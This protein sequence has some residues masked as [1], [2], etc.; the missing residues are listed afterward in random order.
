MIRN[1]SVRT[2]LLT[3]ALLGA[4]CAAWAATGDSFEIKV[5]PVARVT[6]AITIDGDLAESA[7]D[8]APLVDEFTVYGKSDL[9]DPQTH[10]RVI[11][12]DSE[13]LLGIR[14]DEPNMQR[15]TPVGHPRDSMGVF[16][17]ETVEIFV[18]PDHDQATYYQIAVN[19]AESIYDSVKTDPTWSA[20]V[21][22]GVELYD[23]HWTMEVAIPWADLGVAPERGALVGL[24]V[25]RDRYLGAEKSW[26]NWA[27]TSGGW[28]DPERFG[29]IVLSPSASRIGEL[30]E[31]LHR[32]GRSGPV[33]IYG[34]D[35]FVQAANRALAMTAIDQ[36]RE[37]LARLDETRKGEADAAA[38]KEL[39]RRIEDYR[40]EL[41]DFEATATDD[42]VVPREQWREMNHRIAQ[43]R[44]ELH[45]VIWQARVSALLSEI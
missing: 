5:Y 9:N 26:S 34:P 32:G 3:L 18:D 36:A 15:H 21:R 35:A 19:S 38:R 45:T 40:G 20:D 44:D 16:H 4:A 43:M 10:F 8:R 2:V 28:H 37:L 7:W 39:A 14:F 13:L 11:Y 22:A 1:A 33:V 17:G 27:R 12:T 29:H 41:A 23:D 25:C 6:D 31:E 24:N 30:N 42:E